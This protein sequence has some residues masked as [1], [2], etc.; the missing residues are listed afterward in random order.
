MLVPEIALT[1]QTVRRFRARFDRVAVL[2][3]GMTESDRAASWRAIRA[4]E[5]DVVI[6]PR[7]AV[8]APVP[9]L[10]LLV[11]DE[12][13][14]TSFKQQNAPRYHARDVGL[15]RAREAGA[16]VVLGSATPSLES[17]RN[18]LDGKL[19]PARAARARRA[20]ARC[21]PC[22]SWT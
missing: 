15:V 19:R 16:V 4:G 20:A 9:S 10:G 13:H 5:A 14:E 17:Y 11:L 2:H 1:P 18:A 7:S 21:R 12:E 3:S 6:G 8:F 22:A